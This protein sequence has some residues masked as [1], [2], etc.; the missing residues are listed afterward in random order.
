MAQTKDNGWRRETR[1]KDEKNQRE[2]KA[3]RL[4]ICVD[5]IPKPNKH[6]ARWKDDKHSGK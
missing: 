4:G 2:K 5:D 1:R 6:P 3:D